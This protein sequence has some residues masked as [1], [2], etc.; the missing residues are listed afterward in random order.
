MPPD[1]PGKRKE[2][3]EGRKSLPLLRLKEGKR[4]TRANDNV[5]F[6][7]E[8][9]PQSTLV[10]PNGIV[11]GVHCRRSRKPPLALRTGI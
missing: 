3:R 2:K 1:S 6:Y 10:S 9:P 11:I 8:G 7:D 5:Y 4:R